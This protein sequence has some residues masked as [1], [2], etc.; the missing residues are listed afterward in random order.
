MVAFNSTAIMERNHFLWCTFT[1]VIVFLSCVQQIQ[2]LSHDLRFGNCNITNQ[3]IPVVSK[4]IHKPNTGFWSF[5]KK[6]EYTCRLPE[7]TFVCVCMCLF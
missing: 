7:V 1:S 3:T 4:I 6:K 2:C 5:L